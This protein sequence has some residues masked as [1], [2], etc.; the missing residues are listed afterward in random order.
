[1]RTDF[2]S[3]SGKWLIGGY[4]PNASGALAQILCKVVIEQIH[5]LNARF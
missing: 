4:W 3:L 1:M 5:H 2:T